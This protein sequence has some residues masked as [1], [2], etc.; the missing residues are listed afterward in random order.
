MKQVLWPSDAQKKGND[1]VYGW[2]GATFVVAGM[3][4]HQVSVVST[5]SMQP[6]DHSRKRETLESQL[7]V[8]EN[9][10]HSTVHPDS[11][12]RILGRLQDDQLLLNDVNDE[13][14][15]DPRV[16]PTSTMNLNVGAASS[17]II[18]GQRRV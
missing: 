2:A 15:V 7:A 12:P 6:V 13:M 11:Y 17:S 8:F 16:T 10:L 18:A 1:L 3:C 5:L 9:S 14:C 4:G